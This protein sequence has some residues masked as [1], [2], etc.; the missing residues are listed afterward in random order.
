MSVHS[1][2]L[3]WSQV[4]MITL[5][6]LP[7][8]RWSFTQA[9]LWISSPLLYVHFWARSLPHVQIWTLVRLAELSPAASRHL[10]S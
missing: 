5:L 10:P 2:F 8:E 6:P 1:S 3:A 7:P 4:Y 9:P